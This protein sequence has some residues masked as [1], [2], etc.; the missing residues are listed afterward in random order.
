MKQLFTDA[1]ITDVLAPDLPAGGAFSPSRYTGP[2]VMPAGPVCSFGVDPKYAYALGPQHYARTAAERGPNGRF[3]GLSDCACEGSIGTIG[4]RA[5]TG[6]PVLC[7]SCYVKETRGE[8]I[9]KHG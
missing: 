9:G 3:V 7:W 5:V 2:D 6:G 4:Y 1:L 8:R